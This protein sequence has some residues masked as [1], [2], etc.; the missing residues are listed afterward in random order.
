MTRAK[1]LD[2]RLTVV[3]F[4]E[5][6]VLLERLLCL[7]SSQEGK[8]SL[9]HRQLW[10]GFWSQGLDDGY[11]LLTVSLKLLSYGVRANSV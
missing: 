3:R 10:P 8:S 1:S 9:V 2:G 5:A 11:P 4:S 6:T 7:M